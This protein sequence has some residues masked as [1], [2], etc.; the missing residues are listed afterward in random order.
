MY[1]GRTIDGLYLGRTIDGLYPGRTID[2]LYPGRTVDG[3]YPG[4][5]SP[6]S[7]PIGCTC[8][9]EEVHQLVLSK[10]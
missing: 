2:G 10:K 4:Y 8:I 5:L 3:L 7:T 1:L 9:Q 6:D